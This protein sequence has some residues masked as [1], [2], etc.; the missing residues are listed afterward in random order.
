MSDFDECIYS[1]NIIE[2]IKWLDENGYTVVFPQWI[3]V[4][5]KTNVPEYQDGR[6]LHELVDG[7]I[8]LKSDVG[9]PSKVL[10]FKPSCISEMNYEVGAHTCSP[11]GNIKMCQKLNTIHFKNLGIE[12]ILNRYSEYRP[13]M[14][15]INLEKKWGY[16]YSLSNNV[17][18]AYINDNIKNAK[19]IKD[20][21]I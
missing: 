16:H 8:P 2:D 1:E 17:H 6:L 18:K 7:G 13:R 14:S 9:H 12:Y 15:K 11:K 3:E 10:F 4:I 20:I 5:S 19:H 21:L